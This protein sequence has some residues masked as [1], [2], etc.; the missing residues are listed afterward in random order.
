MYPEKTRYFDVYV[1]CICGSG[2]SIDP[3]RTQVKV[4]PYIYV[5]LETYMSS[6]VSEEMENSYLF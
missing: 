4:E 1:K 2:K 3:M 5:D 6:T